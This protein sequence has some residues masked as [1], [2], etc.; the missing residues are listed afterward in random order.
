MLGSRMPN[1]LK[2][3]I[4]NKYH[5][6]LALILTTVFVI[7]CKQ[8]DVGQDEKPFYECRARAQ[9]LYDAKE[10]FASSVGTNEITECEKVKGLL[11]AWAS[12][13]HKGHSLFYDSCHCKILE[14][15]A[16][17]ENK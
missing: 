9:C 3:I 15:Q 13:G 11:I 8:K 4:M 16:R 7:S 10:E 2:G 1:L 17:Q 14:G 5:L 6:W 12:S